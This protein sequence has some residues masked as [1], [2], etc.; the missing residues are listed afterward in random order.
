M[1]AYQQDRGATECQHL[2][3]K[4]PQLT[5][6]DHSNAIRSGNNNAVENS[7]GGSERLSK[8]CVFIRNLLGHRKEIYGGQYQKLGVSTITPDNSEYGS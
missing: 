8:D 7:T 5:V 2:S 4:Q 6:A 3:A 1:L